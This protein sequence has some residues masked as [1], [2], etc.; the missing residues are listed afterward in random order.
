M[1]HKR[2]NSVV[3]LAIILSLVGVSKPAKAFL[4]AQSDT[5]PA[6]FTVPDRLSEDA[7]VKIAASN[8]TD[9]INKG[10]K[11]GFT[12]KYPQAKVEIE[13]E[14]SSAALAS[15]SDGQ[16]DLAAIGRNITEEEKAEGFIAVPVS[17]EKIAVIISKAN[18]YDGNLTIDQ[19]A[20]IFRG[21]ITDW[22]EIGGAPGQIEL[23]DLPDS[24]DTRQ[25]FPNYSVFQSAEFATGDNAI[26]LEE[27]STEAM[28]G[29]LGKN[30]ISYAVA[31]D[32]INRDDVKIVTMHTTQPDDSRYPFS[33]PFNLVYQGTPSETAQAYL[34]YATTEGGREVVASR[35]GSIS[36]AAVTAIA[37]GAAANLADKGAVPLETEAEGQIETIDTDVDESAEGNLDNADDSAN[38][39]DGTDDKADVTVD[40]GAAADVDGVNADIDPDAA[41]E[42]VDT[43]SAIADADIDPD[44]N[45]EVNTD[46]DGSG[47][48][49]TDLDGSGEINTDLDGSGEPL[50]IEGVDGVE[51]EA[52]VPNEGVEETEV[53]AKKGG[54]W[55]LLLIPLLAIPILGALL[56][57]GRKKSDRE[58]A[59]NN[60]PNINSPEGGARVPGMSDDG[61]V[62]PVGANVSGNLGSV[63]ENTVNTTSRM[64][65]AGLAAGGA[66]LA[67]GAAANLA[68]KRRE[69]ENIGDADLDLDLDLDESITA[70]E[71]PSNPVTEFTGQET[72][73]QAGSES[74]LDFDDDLDLDLPDSRFNDTSARDVGFAG[75]AGLGR[76]LGNEVVGESVVES[77]NTTDAELDLDVDRSEMA[78]GSDTNLPGANL[79][80]SNIE[81]GVRREFAGDFVLPEETTDI[82]VS[83]DLDTDISAREVTTPELDLS[84]DVDADPQTDSDRDRGI[85]GGAALGGAALGG[86]AASGMFNR[87]QDA[88]TDAAEDTQINTPNL[89]SDADLDLD[90]DL[91]DRTD[92][93]SANFASGIDRLDVP[94]SSQD[95]DINLG[96]EVTTPELDLS[97]DIDAEPQTNSDL[98]RGIV[99]GAALGGA[100]A[101]GMFNRG[102]DA[103][104]DAA[105]DTQ[106][107][108]P[109]LESDA[110][111]DLDLDLDLGDLT[112][113]SANFTDGVGT[114]DAPNVETETYVPDS[115]QDTD[116]NLDLDLTTPELDLSTDVDRETDSDRGTGIIGGTALGGAALGGAAAASGFFNREEDKTSDIQEFETFETSFDVPADGNPV[117]FADNVVADAETTAIDDSD[118]DLQG[119]TLDSLDRS[120]DLNLDEINLDSE[121]RTINAS[122]EDITFDNASS[123][124]DIHLEGISLDEVELDLDS[125]STNDVTSTGGVEDI[126]LEDLG[127]ADAQSGVES[128]DL[129]DSDTGV[130]SNSDN[131]SNDMN[132]ISE[133]LDSLETPNNDSDN[134]S[135]W[136]DTL[137][138][139]SVNS[140]ANPSNSNPDTDLTE[141]ADDISFQFLEDL[142][143]RDD[144]NRGN[145]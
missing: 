26:Q 66:A 34:G 20:R 64:G 21:E 63:E 19:F 23:V 115:S 62:P 2:H 9:S 145:Q 124:S 35:V 96:G 40:P 36:T 33:Q 99:G 24:N 17:R 49:N 107:N 56:F 109:N 29:Q 90:L 48:V 134:I 15:V 59:V 118:N 12:A 120:E 116:L 117:S 80:G 100:A 18:P 25:A 27:D 52:V 75:T 111:L 73:L 139:D 105:E 103:V 11:D 7:A 143:D 125:P 37:T 68:G 69:T 110:D 10:L 133:W 106:I 13:T 16:A 41:A 71:I 58:P 81:G 1:L 89:E 113:E 3:T 108:T 31:N 92:E 102:Q 6:T 141:E 86:V 44:G 129:Q 65:S 79:D 76:N 38:L 122:L 22:S 87:G 74:E 54:K 130:V 39:S 93:A 132:N 142:L 30:A 126:R 72:K 57:G 140:D 127:F 91:D 98:D 114:V 131:Q 144:T 94:D 95:T 4:L 45:G 123:S 60:V 112:N 53:A 119:M 104:T 28:V 70:Q 84:T 50:S 55:W 61:G 78:V 135:D 85:I 43:D 14:G 47:E 136:L 82:S 8:S 97:T 77:P 88:V 46:L 128:L 51:G 121:D 83:N 42:G 32:V 137:D 138:K 5:A 67:G 101:S